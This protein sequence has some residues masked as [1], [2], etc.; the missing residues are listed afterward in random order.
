MHLS[1]AIIMGVSAFAALAIII[2][3][4]ESSIEKYNIDAQGNIFGNKNHELKNIVKIGVVNP[5]SGDLATHGV[6]NYK[7]IEKAKNDFNNYLAENNHDWQLEFK[8]INSASSPSI[9]NDRINFL[10]R[11]NITTIIGLEQS[12]SISH[13]M[14]NS[15]QNDILLMSCCSTAPE[16]SK[17][18]NLFRL[19]PDDKLQGKAIA[20]VMESNKIKVMIP[21]WRDDIWGNGIQETTS[22]AF[23]EK[24][25]T[26]DKGFIYY[27]NAVSSVNILEV[28][29]VVQE[30]HSKG[31]KFNEIGIVIFGFGEISYL[32]G[33]AN[34]IENN[35]L[36]KVQWFGP[37]AV[38][39]EHQ[40]E[41][42]EDSL[43]FVNRVKLTT[44]QVS[45]SNNTKY[46]EIKE[47]FGEKLKIQNPN[48]FVYPSYDMVW[49][50]GQA[51]ILAQSSNPIEIQKQLNNGIQLQELSSSIN[52]MGFDEN[53]DLRIADYD[54]WELNG[55]WRKIGKYITSADE[56]K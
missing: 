54:I 37:G 38:T 46:E 56:I 5:E 7:S 33:S 52:Q 26:I 48:A 3:V 24:G 53:G 40:I 19:V 28:N 42:N 14:K 47:Y 51:M 34:N 11:N 43:E 29:N 41:E 30:Y 4:S 45:P 39:K 2:P 15:N 9:V 36:D 27:P 10:Y 31:I 55:E 22:K 44:V 16:L 13:F 18:D 49:I 21:I 35:H 12:E 20:K 1:T 17:K 8:K 50:V 6:E 25:G 23:F 32:L